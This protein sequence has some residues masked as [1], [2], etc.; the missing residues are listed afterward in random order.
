MTST[1]AGYE[2]DDTRER[3]DLARVQQ[4][5][6]TTYWWGNTAT[7]SAVTLAF[8]NSALIVG[9][10]LHGQQVGCCR[11]VSDRARFAFLADVFVD[12]AHRK[13]E[14]ARAMSRFAIDHPHVKDVSRFWLVTRDAH[15]VYA[16]LGFGPPPDPT[17]LMQFRR[18]ATGPV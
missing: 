10:Y 9:A 15:D 14:L 16:P 8:E 13:K 18:N 1:H 6:A 11:L 2:I 3:L 5:M 12:P 4:W 7:L 17:L